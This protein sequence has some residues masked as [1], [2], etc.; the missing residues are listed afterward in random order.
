M[1]ERDRPVEL[2]DVPS[3]AGV[4]VTP[5]MIEAGVRALEVH[6]LEDCL[7]DLSRPLAVRAAYLAMCKAAKSCK[8]AASPPEDR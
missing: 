2:G 5:E 6:L 1:S 4:E 3:P 8:S 7:T